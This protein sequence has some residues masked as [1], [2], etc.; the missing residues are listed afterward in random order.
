MGKTIRRKKVSDYEIF[1]RGW[2]DYKP[3]HCSYD[4]IKTYHCG[5][6]CPYRDKTKTIRKFHKDTRSGYGWKGHAPKSFNKEINRIKKAKMKAEVRRI[7]VQGDY[8]DYSFDP[9]KRDAGW[10]YW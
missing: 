8:D 5:I 7:M 6:N 3:G 4:I 1:N 2:C 10:I 9:W